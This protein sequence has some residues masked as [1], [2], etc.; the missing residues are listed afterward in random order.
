MVAPPG[1]QAE[2][3]KTNVGLEQWEKAAYSTTD[4]FSLLD[5]LCGT[6]MTL[7][8]RLGLW[9]RQRITAERAKEATGK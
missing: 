9:D 6:C 8:Q 7:E 3:E 2:T 5:R 1:N 4:C